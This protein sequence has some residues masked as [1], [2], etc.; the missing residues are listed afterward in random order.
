M[1]DFDMIPVI[2]LARIKV[3]MYFLKRIAI[4][5]TLLLAACG[6]GS[7]AGGGL[8]PGDD[9]GSAQALF[10]SC[11][12]PRPRACTREFRPVC[13]KLDNGQLSTFD[14]ACT[15][16]ATESVEGH[17]PEA[18]AAPEMT[19]CSD[20]RPQLCTLDYNPACGQRVTGEARTFGNACQ[21]CGDAAVIGH[22]AGE[23]R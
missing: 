14:N 8:E 17:Y 16:C 1:I 4:M 11:Q 15:A 13:A 3:I 21:A 2:H 12:D 18:C 6:G 5:A 20:P 10:T 19:A 22:F 23:C 7:H 9:T